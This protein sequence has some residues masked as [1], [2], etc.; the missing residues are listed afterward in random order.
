MGG[1]TRK[2]AGDGIPEL[3]FALLCAAEKTRGFREPLPAPWRNL[4]DKLGKMRKTAGGLKKVVESEDDK[5]NVSFPVSSRC[6]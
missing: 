4:R 3:R 1:E 2:L 5:T 6:T